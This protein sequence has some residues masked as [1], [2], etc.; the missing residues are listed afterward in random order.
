[1]K[2]FLYWGCS[3]EGSGSNFLVSL[4]P[5]CEA[6]G[7][8]FLEIEDWN[9]CGASVSYAGANDLAIKVLNARNLAI[10]E[11]EGGYDVVA[12]CSSCYIQM[13]KVNH[14]IKENPKLLEDVNACLAEG[15][16]KYHGNLNVR[17]I[18]DVL[19]NDIGVDKIKEKV[20]KP[21]NGLK[22][23]GYVGCQSVRPYGE[24]DSV[25]KPVVQDR[26]IEALGAEAVPFPNKIKCC[27]S[28]LFVPEMDYCMELVKNILE[29]ALDHGAKLI[30]TVCPMCAMNLELYQGRINDKYGTNFDVPIVY[31]TQ[32]MAIAFGMDMKKHAALNYNVIPPEGVIHA[33]IG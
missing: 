2:Y 21:L 24:Y 5:P 8:D 6:L 13:I 20:V 19:Y 1:M 32:L 26:L 27:G 4:K 22:V 28:G 11:A 7:M 31:L 33:A 12:P 14:E 17:H 15:G 9:C 3:L 10:A 23:A 16:L 25:N 18:Q 30:S 29:D